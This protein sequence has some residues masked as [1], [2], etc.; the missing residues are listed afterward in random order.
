MLQRP[1]YVRS[2]TMPVRRTVG[3]RPHGGS[4]RQSRVEIYLHFVW[5]TADRM[6]LIK[7][8]IRRP[9]YRCLEGQARETGC[10][11]L[12]IGGMP[13]HVHL[14]LRMPATAAAAKVV[15]QLKG[16]SSK[17]VHDE[18][19]ARLFKWQEGYGAFSI[20]RGHVK[21]V[22]AYVEGQADHHAGGELWPAFE[23]TYEEIEPPADRPADG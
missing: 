23:E 13:D 22:I 10:T 2:N 7:P 21:R 17:F 1:E 5:A 20:S 19:G 15:Q 4:M 6:W 3:H 8:T 16:V 11:V 12:A 18:L 9:L 14:L